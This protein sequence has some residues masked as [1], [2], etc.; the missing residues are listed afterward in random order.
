MQILINKNKNILFVADRIEFGI[1]D[2]PDVRKWAL[3]DEGDERPQ[4]YALDDNYTKVIYDGE[5]P[6]DIDIWGKYLYDG[7]TI[8]PDPTYK[9]PEEIFDADESSRRI[10]QLESLVAQLMAERD[11]S[12]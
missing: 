4:M 11:D 9:E 1:F 10:K 3:Y 5:L 6:S 2:E 12:K 8:V 7:T